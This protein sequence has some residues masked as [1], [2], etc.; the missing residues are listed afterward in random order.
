MIVFIGD[1]SPINAQNGQ[2]ILLVPEDRP[3]VILT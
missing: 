3:I 1:Y 2:A